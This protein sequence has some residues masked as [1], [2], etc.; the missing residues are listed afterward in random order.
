MSE[1]Y[2]RCVFCENKYRERY[3]DALGALCPR[4]ADKFR[5]YV[6][7]LKLR[8]RKKKEFMKLM[9]RQMKEAV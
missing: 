3:D 1:K 2:K 5:E 7:Y 6:E 9:G 8:G 4:C